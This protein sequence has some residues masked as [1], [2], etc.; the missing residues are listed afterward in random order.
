[1]GQGVGGRVGN[2]SF[3][4]VRPC[5]TL[6]LSCPKESLK[7]LPRFCASSHVIEESIHI[8]DLVDVYPPA[9]VTIRVGNARA[10]A[11]VVVTC[12][13]DFVKATRKGP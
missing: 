4:S 12:R 13:H 1:M 3:G 8:P 7:T 6:L 10:T 11:T 9:R 5:S 2:R